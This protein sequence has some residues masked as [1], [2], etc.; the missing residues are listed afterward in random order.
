M[1]ETSLA[2]EPARPSRIMV[3]LAEG[4]LDQ[5]ELDAIVTWISASAS[6]ASPLLTAS[7]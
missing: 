4:R 6:Q 7:Q 5:A 1:R 2:N 3:D